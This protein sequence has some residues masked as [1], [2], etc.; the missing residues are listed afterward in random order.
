METQTDTLPAAS[1]LTIQPSVI[2]TTPSSEQSTDMSTRIPASHE[3]S[4]CLAEAAR[5]L[6]G[7]LQ[8]ISSGLTQTTSSSGCDHTW[9]RITHAVTAEMIAAAV[10]AAVPRTSTTKPSYYQRWTGDQIRLLAKTLKDDAGCP[11]SKTLARDDLINLLEV[12]EH[13]ADLQAEHHS[14]GCVLRF[15]QYVSR[16]LDTH[17]TG[18]SSK[19][20]AA[21]AIRS[22]VGE[23][24]P[25][26]DPPIRPMVISERSTGRGGQRRGRGRGGGGGGGNSSD[27][28]K[29]S[30]STTVHPTSDRR[31]GRGH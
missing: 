7:T 31:G 25:L 28:P 23:L 3:C 10:S 22:A 14:E 18:R 4:K 21:D 16:A 2:S 20:A 5:S 30:T 12:L 17:T 15:Q 13:L 11:P 1:P 26:K 29:R 24:V 6:D 8:I 9:T 19:A 27:H